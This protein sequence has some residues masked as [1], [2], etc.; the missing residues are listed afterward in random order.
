VVNCTILAELMDEAGLL[1]TCADVTSMFILTE[2]Y[3]SVHNFMMGIKIVYQNGPCITKIILVVFV[4]ICFI[5]I[6]EQKLKNVMKA[7]R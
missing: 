7:V 3:Y 6:H 4:G 1:I 5:L 2:T